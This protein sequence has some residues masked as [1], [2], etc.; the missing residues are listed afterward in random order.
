MFAQA[1]K[2]SEGVIYSGQTGS[3]KMKTALGMSQLLARNLTVIDCNESTQP[4]VILRSMQG[5]AA[6]SNMTL[7]VN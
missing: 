5:V 6:V 3:G 2:G 4:E 7:L 1:I